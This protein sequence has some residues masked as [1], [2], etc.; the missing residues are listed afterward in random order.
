MA[1]KANKYTEAVKGIAVEVRGDTWTYK[2]VVR[3]LGTGGT[4]YYRF[5]GRW[6][7]VLWDS[8]PKKTY[9]KLRS[10]LRDAIEWQTRRLRPDLPQ[11][12]KRGPIQVMLWPSR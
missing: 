7:L 8:I 12:A 5:D 1:R 3:H 2:A 6:I 9:R 4:D 10:D 11:W